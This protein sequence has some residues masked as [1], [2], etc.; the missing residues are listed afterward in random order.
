MRVGILLL[1][2]ACAKVSPVVDEAD[3]GPSQPQIAGVDPQPGPVAADAHF[4]V[5]FSSAMNEGQL[6]ASSGGSET[7]VL[8]AEADVERAAAA[9]AHDRVTAEERRLFVPAQ[10]SLASDLMAIAIA[11]DRPLA[12]GKFYL[13][14]SPRLKD[15]A[16][17]KLPGNGA[18]F[19][20]QI[21]APAAKARLVSPAAGAEAATDLQTV[22]ATAS[23]GHVALLGPDGGV[24]AGPAEAQGEVALSLAAPLTAGAK[25]MLALEGAASPDESF[26]AAPCV[27]TAPPALQNG[28]AALAVR[29][30][31]VSAQVVL[32]W[33]ARVSLQ[34]GEAGGAD[35][36]ASGGCVQTEAFIAC[37]PPACGPQA[38]AC[39][40]VLRLG[41]L[42]AASDYVLRV[43]AR[44]DYGFTLVGPQQKF[45]TIAP[46]PRVL[47]SEVMSSPGKPVSGAEYVEILN[48]GPGAAA[49]D[50]FALLGPD[51]KSRA[52]SAVPPPVPVLL[53]PGARA[54]AVGSG[55]DASRYPSIPPGTPVLRA[56]T[57]RPLG[58]GLG[59]RT[60]PAFQLVLLGD[61]PVE[62][63]AFPGNAQSCPDGASL[64]RDESVPPD[65]E[66]Q[67]SCGPIGGTPGAPP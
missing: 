66:A 30:T 45:T 6:L 5:H 53:A 12:A 50:S 41:G 18:R 8:A 28:Q 1:A 57:K 65:G 13:L 9:I 42:K 36:C 37:A 16:G 39:A 29:D 49:L 63:A 7:V 59:G 47:I 61:V 56:S 2:L 11:P 43:T 31:E 15:N 34:V 17:R 62:L 33:P 51:G 46:L 60:P 25:Y 23:S 67:W 26:T 20:Y 22:R 32:D 64:Q 52:L 19:E 38:F 24:V 54:L 35:P 40:G 4:T 48:L 27:R 14:V 10:A 55:F 44:D 21:A 58:H 3:G